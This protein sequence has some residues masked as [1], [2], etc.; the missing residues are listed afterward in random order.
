M[1]KM[2]QNK[3]LLF[4]VCFF[5]TAILIIF[6]Y[7]GILKPVE[8]VILKFF[9]PVS[10]VFFN[11]GDKLK[12]SFSFVVSIKD[13]AKE[14]KQLSLELE[15]FSV[16]K[17]QLEE[18][19]KENEELRQQLDY[20][21]KSEYELISSVVVSK[22]P[23]N[24]LRIVDINKGSNDGIEEDDLVIVSDGI[25]IGRVTETYG[26][27]AK[28]LLIIDINSHIQAKIQD[29]NA[30]G[31]VSGEHGLGLI[32]NLIPQDKVVKKGDIVVTS[33]IEQ[34]SYSLLIGEVEE[35]NNSDNELF[36]KV[37]I[38]SP[39]DFKELKYVFVVKNK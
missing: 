13:L 16:D 11:V 2:S 20:K 8:S 17:A 38:K 19:K 7:V 35:V 12:N 3:F 25:L 15:S 5:I 29:S 23:A 39:V 4:L 1:L 26:D 34:N 9:S 21:S 10:K 18:L 32:M 28:V 24:L 36:Q 6:H 37:R 31:V 14:N 27:F 30:D 33:D 22:D